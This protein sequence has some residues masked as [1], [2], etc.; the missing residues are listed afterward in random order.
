MFCGLGGV[1]GECFADNPA[2]IEFTGFLAGFMGNMMV[3]VSF[4]GEYFADVMGETGFLKMAIRNFTTINDYI[5][6][7]NRLHFIC[8]L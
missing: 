1:F 4:Y 6:T 2:G 3:R 8:M 7:Q 5:L